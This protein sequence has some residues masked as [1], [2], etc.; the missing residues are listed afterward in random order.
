MNW[1]T[2]S[3]AIAATT[4]SKA[5]RVTMYSGAA[6]DDTL[7]GGA[8]NDRLDGG[9]GD[10]TY[11]Y[12]AGDGADVI[13]DADGNDTLLLGRDQRRLGTYHGTVGTAHAALAGG[14]VEME[15]KAG[16]L[17]DRIQFADGTVWHARAD[18]SGYV[19]ILGG[20]LHITGDLKQGQTVSL[21]TALA[22]QE[23]PGKVSY[24][25]E[26]SANGIDWTVIAGA[27]EALL[28]LSADL[29]GHRLRATMQSLLEDGK[30]E[31]LVSAV[32]ET[33]GSAGHGPVEAV[34]ISGELMPGSLW[35]SAIQRWTCNRCGLPMPW[36]CAH[37]GTGAS[38]QAGHPMGPPRGA[39]AQHRQQLRP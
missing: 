10:D 35:P 36:E 7:T 29:V 9:S 21:D 5:W 2:T 13:Q 19:Q 4:C 18:G 38:G 8:G 24:R 3:S 25:W 39:G 20:P 16:K 22:K 6:G 23:G 11:R 12:A 32:S 34:R 17:V 33:V 15:A 37:T 30:Q 27:T 31:S 14:S 26:R 1:P 28:L